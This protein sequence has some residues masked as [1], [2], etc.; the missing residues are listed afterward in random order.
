MAPVVAG[1]A[2]AAMIPRG[3]HHSFHE[4][5][6]HRRAR[7]AIAAPDAF[8][9]YPAAVDLA[10]DHVVIVVDDLAGATRACADA[11]FQVLAGGRH[12]VTPT[13]NALIVLA[14]GGYLELL[15]PRDADARESLRVRSER[16]SWAAELRRANAV[17]RRFLP[18]LVGPTGVA[19]F[20]LRTG[21]LAAVARALRRLDLAATGPVPMGR[22]RPDG[23]RLDWKL[24]LPAAAW[25]PFFIQD[26]TPRALRVP[27]EGGVRV[28][29]NG[30][31]AVAA[32][33]VRVD[34]SIAEVALAYADLF[35]A[36][37][38][39]QP[40]GTTTLDLAGVRIVLEHGAPPGARGVGVRGLAT[41][42]SEIARL[43]IE[44]LD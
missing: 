7:R 2:I 22:E 29:A 40:D 43:G 21:D 9:A 10:F 23:V 38:R 28:H 39:A 17:A 34:S 4:W 24:L 30:A 32:V 44:P 13:A 11:G 5:R 36:S 12:D 20:V 42:S 26:L 3:I 16:R 27:D 33:R 6:W 14:D 37:P 18:H 8:A 15:A 31:R 19:D 35:A 41:A 25:L 1:Q